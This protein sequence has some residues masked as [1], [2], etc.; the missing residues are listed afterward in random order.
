MKL[1]ESGQVVEAMRLCVEER[2]NILISG[3]TSTGKTTFARAL[4]SMV[5]QR[6][7]IL[8]IEDAYELFPR[9]ENAV[10]FKADR[11][12]Q[13]ERT[14]A[15][16][17]EA[18]LRMRPDRII[19]GELRGEE[20]RT[21]LEAINTGHGGSFTTIHAD[22]ARKAIDRLAI[23]VMAAGLGMGFEEVKRYCE[24]SVDLVVQLARHGG[25]RG[26]AEIVCL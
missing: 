8:T 23:M 16:L 25:R 22:T 17:L 9:Q 3:G 15:R 6:E 5:D 13:G 18:S 11:S 10:T 4:L 12:G 26:V 20:S 21:F 2:M 24:G 1:A 7:R 14:P 19:L